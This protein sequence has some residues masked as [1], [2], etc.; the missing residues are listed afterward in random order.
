MAPFALLPPYFE[1]DSFTTPQVAPDF[2]RRIGLGIRHHPGARAKRGD[3]RIDGTMPHLAIDRTRPVAIPR[4]IGDL[5]RLVNTGMRADRE[6][7][8]P[9][10]MQPHAK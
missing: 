9:P 5:T 7:R 8:N 1:F 10:F 4:P 3:A 2:A 6:T